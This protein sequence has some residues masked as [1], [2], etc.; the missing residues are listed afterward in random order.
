M[1]DFTLEVQNNDFSWLF[2]HLAVSVLGAI[3]RKILHIFNT[4]W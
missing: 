1:G 4:L 2:L 3:Y